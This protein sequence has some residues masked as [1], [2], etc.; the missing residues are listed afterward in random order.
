MDW[1]DSVGICSLFLMANLR[2][3]QDYIIRSHGRGAGHIATGST[4]TGMCMALDTI[5]NTFDGTERCF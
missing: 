5:Y 4:G 1:I 3:C 2:Q